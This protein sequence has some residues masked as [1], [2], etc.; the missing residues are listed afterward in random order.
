MNSD[1]GIKNVSS[2]DYSEFDSIANDLQ[3][4]IH[5]PAANAP[6]P[7]NAAAAPEVAFAINPLEVPMQTKP[8]I[9][10][11]SKPTR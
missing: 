1:V 5:E 8:L 2:S 9:I 4:T 11:D 7:V 3:L 6:E 10:F